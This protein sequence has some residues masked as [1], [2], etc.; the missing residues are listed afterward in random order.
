MKHPSS[1]R[2]S[3]WQ[4]SKHNRGGTPEQ[5]GEEPGADTS[6]DV[7]PLPMDLSRILETNRRLEQEEDLSAIEALIWSRIQE[8]LKVG[9]GG[10]HRHAR[11]G[12]DRHAQPVRAQARES[13]IP[14][15]TRPRREQTHEQGPRD[16][17]TSPI[18]DL[19]ALV[20][21]KDLTF[22]VRQIERFGVAP[23]D[24]DDVTQEV[25]L[26]VFRSTSRCNAGRAKRT[27][28][29]Y[30][31]AFYQSMSFRARAY[32]RREALEAMPPESEAFGSLREKN[33]PETLAI[34]KEDRHLVWKAIATIEPNPRTV[35]V[36]YEIVEETMD[37]IAQALGIP[38]STGWSRLLRARKQFVVALRRLHARSTKRTRF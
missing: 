4:P 37:E 16:T 30:R 26:G 28:W 6:P 35:F 12:A 8:K 18:A 17:S 34:A 33:D 9:E 20:V 24:I 27:T 23:A 21:Q 14:H 19:F 32:H 13:A 7:P 15:D 2:P 11:D 25:L 5:T 38:M 3:R 36:A 29:L 22:I 10:E 1:P 31:V